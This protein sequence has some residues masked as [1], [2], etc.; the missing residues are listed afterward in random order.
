[1]MIDRSQAASLGKM[2]EAF[3]VVAPN[4]IAMPVGAL[5]L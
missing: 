2:L 5:I 4:I 3:P 1:M